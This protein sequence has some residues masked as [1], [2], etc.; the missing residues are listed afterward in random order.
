MGYTVT[1]E[2]TRDYKA[3][4]T[5]TY[6]DQNETASV[7]IGADYGVALSTVDRLVGEGKDSAADYTNT[8]DSV[9]PTGLHL[10]DLPFIAMIAL[11][12]LGIT[13][14]IMIKSRK[15]KRCN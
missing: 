5:I 7:S 4:C 12:I 10:N 8:H 6:T 15:M 9:T 13:G 1:E 3:K 2:A 11:A 14:Y